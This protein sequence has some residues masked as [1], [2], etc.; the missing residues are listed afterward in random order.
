MAVSGG[1]EADKAK[2]WVYVLPLYPP[3]VVK[4]VKVHFTFTP[5]LLTHHHFSLKAELVLSAFF[6]ILSV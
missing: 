4:A 5:L 3:Y 6:H 1:G 2:D